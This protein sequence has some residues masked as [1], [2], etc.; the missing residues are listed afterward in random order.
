MSYRKSGFNPVAI[1]S[2]TSANAERVA[3][4]HGVEHAYATYEQV[5]DDPTIEVLDIAVPPTEQPALIRAACQRGTVKAILAQ[6]PLALS[7]AAATETVES[8]EQQEFISR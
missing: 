1:A 3:K 4:D 2:R 7:L 8:C 5:L 6:K